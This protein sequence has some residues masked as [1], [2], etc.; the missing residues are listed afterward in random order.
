MVPSPLKISMKI[1][2]ATLRIFF[3]PSIS[4]TEFNSHARRKI[5]GLAFASCRLELDVL[6][7]AG[8]C[9]VETVAQT[10]Y[11]AVHLNAAVRQEHHLENNITFDLPTTSFR[12]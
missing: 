5:H 8:R 9:F 6:R 3:L 12:G 4:H 11:D 1:D 10:A 7:C 2:V